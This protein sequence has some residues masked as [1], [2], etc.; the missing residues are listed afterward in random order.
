MGSFRGVVRLAV[1]TALLAG[2]GAGLLHWL[3]GSLLFDIPGTASAWWATLVLYGVLALE[4]GILTRYFPR[5]EA[6]AEA[7]ARQRVRTAP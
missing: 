1:P 4:A 5:T 2:A 6:E 3:G 7:A